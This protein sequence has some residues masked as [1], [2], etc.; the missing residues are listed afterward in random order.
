MDDVRPKASV[1]AIVWEFEVRDGAEK[2]FEEAYGP[3]GAW[4]RLF[5]NADGFLGTELLRDTRRP[6]R[7]LT[8]D[9]WRSLED[10]AHFR[11]THRE[12]YAALDRRCEAWTASE[13]ALGEWD[14]LEG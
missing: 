10:F 14:V 8:I 9:R 5:R 1:H 11:Q 3:D 7:Y 6:R 12:E 4:A 13:V 2:P